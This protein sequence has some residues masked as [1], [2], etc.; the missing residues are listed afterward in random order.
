MQTRL[1]RFAF[2]I[3]LIMACSMAGIAQSRKVT[4]TVKD[5]E[6]L[7]VIGATVTVPGTKAAAITDVDGKYTIDVPSGGKKIKVTYVGS[8]DAV[9]DIGNRDVIDVVMTESDQSLDEVVAIGYAKVRKADLTGATASVSAEDLASRPVATAA[10]ALAGKAAGVNIVSQS[11]APGADINI[12]VRGGTSITQSTTPLYI[13]DGFEMENALQQIDINDI[14]TIDI[15]KDASATAIYGARGA[16]GVVIITT[17]NAK[18]GKTQVNYNTYYSWNWL[19]KKLDVLNTLDYVKY[20]YEFQTLAGNV[21]NFAS[22]Y[23]GDVNDPDFYTGAYDRINQEYG[24]RTG[25]DWQDE[26]FGGTG[27]SMN[28]NLSISGGTE[29]TKYLLSYNFTGEDGILSKHG[30]DKNSIRLKLNHELWKGV[31][32]DFSTSFQDTKV[33]GGGSMAGSLKNVIL[34]PPTGG[35]RFTD[36]E[37]LSQDLS[38]E[39]MS[40]DSQYDIDNPLINNASISN[41]SHRRL[42]TMNAGIEFD[43]LKDFTWRT[44]GSYTWMQRRDD[45]WDNGDTRTAKNYGGAYGYRN[46]SERT[47]WQITNTLNWKHSFYLHH[48]NVLFGHEVYHRGTLK[49]D[50]EYHN[51]PEANFG[52]NNVTMADPY[53]WESGTSERGLVSFFG[54]AS[55]DWNDR[56]LFTATLRTDGS[57]K[58]G[59]GHRWGWFPSASAAWRITEEPWMQ[60]TKSWLSNLKL[61]L[62]FGTTGNDNIDD[63]MY[64][65]P[66]G[67]AYYTNGKEVISGLS[68][69]SIV[70]NP[71]VKWEKTSTFNLGLDFGFFHGRLNGSLDYYV[72]KSSNLLIQNRIPTSTGYTYQY[73]N[74]AKIR[75]R[76]FEAVINSTNIRTKDFTWTT[77]FNI[78]FNKNKVLKLY[79]GAN[80]NNYFIQD[81]D[82]RM[83]FLIQEG[84]ELGQFYGYKTDGVYTTDDFTQ[85][86][87]GTYTLKDGVPSLKG[88]NRKNIKPGD[89]KYQTTAGQ[90]DKNGNPVWSTDDRQVIGHANPDFTGGMN[91]TFRYKGFDLSV[92]LTF[93]VGGDVFNMN[94][95][96]YVGPYLPNQN[97]IAAMANHYILVDPQ[98]GKETTD[99][100]RL[101]ELNPNQYSK[102]QMWSL[103][104]DNKIAISDPLDKYI[105]DG[106]YLRFSTI[107]LGYT[108]PKSL[109]SKIC[110]QNLRIYATLNNIATITGYDGFDP[111]VSASGSALTPGIDNSAYPRSKSFVVGLNLTF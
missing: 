81:Y 31:R 55:Y 104:A 57:S 52:L 8:K 105:E 30:L 92:F 14:E 1:R 80:D 2:V 46:N 62:G 25:I 54:R 89:I 20:Q 76:G 75:N 94:T 23:G 21:A 3:Y 66:Y 63:N 71:N 69:G 68:P 58:F 98:T 73:Q 106:S 6:G 19:G 97:T 100:A 93:S 108:F 90:T 82:S 101:A 74:L 70:G 84:S 45:Y 47:T 107:T 15:M 33:E 32:F 22:F 95:Q 17:K 36:Q 44:A 49:L 56:Y 51:F 5:T 60:S 35:A 43:F 27:S 39:M 64:A 48:V 72:N 28:H 13:V 24:N 59:K 26:V 11:G 109:M 40:I 12:T 78:S 110:V 103:H 7:E 88:A 96:R 87:D 77:D 10:E 18:E 79:G 99:L 86:A 67:V 4:G 111:E 61:R 85:N 41:N 38:D 42:W 65:T 50:N 9:I 91:N 34:Q 37:F 16:N 53:S 102:G 29:K 83:W